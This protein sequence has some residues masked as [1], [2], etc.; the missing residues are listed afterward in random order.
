[1]C[2][3]NDEDLKTKEKKMFKKIPVA[4]ANMHHNL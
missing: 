1:M 3:V 2:Y 4:N